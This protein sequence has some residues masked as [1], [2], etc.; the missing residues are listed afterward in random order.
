MAFQS[1][2]FA[3]LKSSQVMLLLVVKGPHFRQKGSHPLLL[4]P[5]C[6]LKSLEGLQ[7]TYV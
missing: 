6:T 5:D 1:S 3:V 7:N 4:K 2:E